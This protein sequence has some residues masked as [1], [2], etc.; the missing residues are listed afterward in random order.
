MWATKANEEVAR[1][2]INILAEKNCTVSESQ[3]ILRYVSQNLGQ[4][5]TVQKADRELFDYPKPKENTDRL[6]EEFS[7]ALTK[8]VINSFPNH[9]KSQES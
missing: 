5:A 6:V 1:T 4:H 9:D 3:E 8:S 7:T 2:I